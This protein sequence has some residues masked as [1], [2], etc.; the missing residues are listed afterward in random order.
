VHLGPS[1]FWWNATRI[2]LAIGIVFFALLLWAWTRFVLTAR[3][4]ET[5][6]IR[7][8]EES[9]ESCALDQLCSPKERIET[10]NRVSVWPFFVCAPLVAWL[11]VERV[12]HFQPAGGEPFV[13]FEGISIWPTEVIRLIAIF[14]AIIF[15]WKTD[16]ALA[17]SNENVQDDFGLQPPGPKKPD[18]RLWQGLVRRLT[19]R[20][21]LVQHCKTRE[22]DAQALWEEYLLSGELGRRWLRIVPLIVLY[23]LAASCLVVA[24]G[25]PTVPFRGDYCK[26]WDVVTLVVAVISST[27]ITFYVADATLLNRRLIHYLTVSDTRWPKETYKKLRARR[28]FHVGG[29]G[30]D[31]PPATVLCDYLETEL[32]ATRTEVVGNLIYYP[33]IVL[34]LMVVSRSSIFDRW[35]WPVSLILVL[36]F[37]ATYAAWSA[38][39]LRHSAE[40]ARR[41]TLDRLDGLL[42]GHMAAESPDKS[43][44]DVIREIASAIRA[45]NRGAFASISHHPIFGAILLP[46]GG[47]GIWAL[48]QYL[49]QFLN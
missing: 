48:T 45:E 14:L 29:C 8:E 37:N 7:P 9:D 35:D 25:G 19:L 4:P 38:F 39:S 41:K 34:F 13:W 49:P 33:F 43:A 11:I 12:V 3:P 44:I 5:K 36:L 22:I 32:I 16:R 6:M 28:R 26:V 15:V 18:S 21:W 20:Y 17:I 23:L 2:C 27:A 46:S 30:E 10:G 31:K 47:L 1:D 24:L 42:V 40:A